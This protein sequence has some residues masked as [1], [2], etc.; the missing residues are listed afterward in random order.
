MSERQRADAVWCGARVATMQVG[1]ERQLL[2]DAAVAVADGRILAVGPSADVLARF[3]A[4]EVHDLQGRLLTPGLV[5]CHTHLVWAGSRAHEFERR[6]E[7]ASYADIAAAGGGIRATVRAVRAASED[8]LIAESLPRLDA[9][10]AEGVTTLEIK[11]GYGLSVAEEFKQLRAARRL[12][13][14]RRVSVRTTLL[15]AHAMPPGEARTPDDYIREVCEQ[16]IP[17]AAELRLADAVDAYCEHLAFNTAQVRRVFAAARLAGLPVKL[18]AGQLSDMGGAEL[19]AASGA[20]SVDHLEYVSEGAVLAMA[21]AGS[22][23]VLLPGAFYCLRETQRPPVPLLRRHAVPMAVATDCNP[24]TSPLSSPLLAM[25][26]ACTLF[27]LTVAEA[28]AGFTREAARALGLADE[29]GTIEVGKRA[30]LAIWNLEN[31]A[32]LVY[33]LGHRPLHARVWRGHV[34]FA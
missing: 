15:G 8:V 26:M 13:E 22:V 20:L 27:G 18:H 28:L 34:E 21:H 24:G 9:L 33:R 32:E 17:Q 2:Q 4:P 11:S 1:R 10:Q 30:D 7:G 14:L 23:A 25:N 3:E 16:M 6:L 12:G 31:P 19:A 29:I 5:D